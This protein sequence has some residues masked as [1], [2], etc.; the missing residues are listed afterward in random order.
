MEKLN[1]DVALQKDILKSKV[2]FPNLFLNLL[3]F[4]F[5]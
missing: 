4:S 5:Y 3:L 1:Q 2:A